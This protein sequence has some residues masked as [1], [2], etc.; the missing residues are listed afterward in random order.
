M[1]MGAHGLGRISQANLRSSTSSRS[2]R[3]AMP[4]R[5]ERTD[6]RIFSKGSHRAQTS[7]NWLRVIT[8]SSLPLFQR[9]TATVASPKG[10]VSLL[11]HTSDHSSSRHGVMK[12]KFLKLIHH[13]TTFVTA[14]TMRYVSYLLHTYQYSS[15]PMRLCRVRHMEP[16]CMAK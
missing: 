13:R 6:W 1:T 10:L 11:I 8:S 15:A 9:S 12:W 2:L 5:L 16:P 14:A 4:S 7:A 3:H